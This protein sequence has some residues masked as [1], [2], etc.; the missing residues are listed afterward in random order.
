MPSSSFIT[1]IKLLQHNKLDDETVTLKIRKNRETELKVDVRL[2]NLRATA[3]DDTIGE[4]RF[5]YGD[6]YRVEIDGDCVQLRFIVSNF[7]FS[8]TYDEPGHAGH[9]GKALVELSDGCNSVE[10]VALYSDWL[11]QARALVEMVGDEGQVLGR[12][13]RLALEEIDRLQQKNVDLE[14]KLC[15]NE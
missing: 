2:S 7:K 6:R 8:V 14:K 12:E 10:F 3:W 9:G 15:E 1:L 4:K 11:T 5:W 13:L